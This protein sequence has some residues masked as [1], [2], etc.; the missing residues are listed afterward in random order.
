MEGGD[1]MEDA[2]KADPEGEAMA[3]ESTDPHKYSGDARDYAG[4]ANFPA[5]LLRNL[6]VN[7]SF[8]D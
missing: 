1:E 3:M 6:I 7:A 5:L 2:A 4:W 8:F